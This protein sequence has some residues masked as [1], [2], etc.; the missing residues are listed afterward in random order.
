MPLLKLLSS[1]EPAI[2][3]PIIT[4]ESK[5]LKVYTNNKK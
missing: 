2:I 5:L 3:P 4:I 1:I